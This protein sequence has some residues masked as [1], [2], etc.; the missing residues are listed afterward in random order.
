M[1]MREEQCDV[2]VIGSG[3]AGLSTAVTAQYEGLKVIVA[4][5]A[6]KFGGTSARS[7]GWLWVPCTYLAKEWGHQDSFEKVKTF[8]KYECGEF[9]DEERVN[10]FLNHGNEAIE[11]L[12]KKTSVRFDMPL[13]L[14]DY[15]SE[16]PGGKTGGRTMGSVPFDARE[17]GEHLKDMAPPLPELTVF[18]MMIGSGQEIKHFMRAFKSVESFKYTVVRFMKYFVESLKYGRG[19]TLTNGNA[20]IGRLAKSAFDLGVQIWVKSPAQEL[21]FENGKVCGAI[22]NKNGT[23]VRV[24]AN[25]GVVLAAGGFS[26]NSQ[27]RAKLYPHAPT[28]KEHWSPTAE[29]ITGDSLQMV[30][31]FGVKQDTYLPHAAAWVPVS[32]TKRKDGS[33]GV[34]PHFIDRAKP[35]VIAVTRKGVRFT[36]EA[37]SY[38][39]FVQGMIAAHKPGE[40]IYSWLVCDHNTLRSYGLGC[41]PP[42][43]LPIGKFL[44]SGYLK[45][46]S[47]LNELAEIC[48]IDKL[49]F[50]NTV[51][52]YNQIS[53]NGRD[54][55]FGKGWA[56]YNRAQGDMYHAPNP[57]VRP[58]GKGPYYAIQ[59]RI[60]DLGSYAGI[61]VDVNCRV[62]DQ[63]GQIVNGLYA[64][65]NDAT[66]IMGGG[67]PAG[68]ITLGPAVVFGYAVGKQLKNGAIH[69]KAAHSAAV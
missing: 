68:G 37:A 35:G 60:G 33:Q 54:P 53:V 69:P 5:K 36:N 14:P 55:D 25:K 27:L 31:K 64:V 17:L 16:S 65:G 3:A 59:I 21:L 61:P 63:S 47:S 22:I 11:F 29:S 10:A 51:K 49:A 48:D 56:A 9:Y 26:H 23:Q 39:D 7:G 13:A 6:E 58:I 43:P 34:M 66:S 38:H 19:M 44:S 8:L 30:S 28:G 67:Y 12:T 2:L 45:K 18:G 15:H 32:L 20:L 4:E 41:V 40:D 52:R 24:K 1:V 62:L 46:A 50:A 42:A 57:C